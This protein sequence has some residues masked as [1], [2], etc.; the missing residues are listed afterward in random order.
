MA[1]KRLNLLLLLL[2]LLQGILCVR[3]QGHQGLYPSAGNRKV[4]P[5]KIS[6]FIDPE[7]GNDK[8]PGT[9]AG[10]A[11][12]TFSKLNQMILSPGDK[13][14]IKPGRFHQSLVLI[15]R[16]SAKAPVLI[17][18]AHGRFDVFPDS[19]YREP[20]HISNTND[21]PYEPKAI[22]L[23]IR[24]SH[25]VQVT[26]RGARLIMRG[27]IIETFINQ[28]E[29]VHV[30]GLSYD[31]HRPTVSELKATTVTALYA[32]LEIHPQSAYSIKDSLLT[33]EGEGWRYQPG[34]YWQVFEPA[35][36]Y[37]YR[38]GI[39]FSTLKIAGTG[40][41]RI[42]A[43][44]SKNPGFTA[45]SIYQNRDVTRDCAGIVLMRS[46]NISLK[47]L[48]IYFMH[49]MGVVSQFCRNIAIDDLT[50][51]PEEHS[52]KTCAAWADILHFSGCSGK[53]MVANSYLSAAN[54]DAIN[55]HGTH[56]RITEKLTDNKL[57]V[58]FMHGQTYGFDPFVPGDTADFIRAESLRSFGTNVVSGVEQ[59]NDKEF[60]LTF[61]NA[62]PYNLK[63]NDV[64]E[65]VTQTPSVW[66]HHTT[67]TLVPT[68]GMLVTTRRKVVIE[69]NHFLRTRYS[70]ILVEDDAE[71]WYESGVVRDV[72]IRKNTFVDCG[73]PV[74]SIHPENHL[75]DGPVHQNIT[76]L[77]NTF[78]L[79]NTKI[80]TA[81]STRNITISQ[82]RIISLLPVTMESLTGFEDCT[83]IEISGNVVK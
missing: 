58:R 75:Y 45:G 69:N 37:V 64:L 71:S 38:Q 4:S 49:G 46:E 8:N 3:A 30:E 41:H 60:I 67:L 65:N 39:Q 22:A 27:K 29:N 19:L 14:S 11:W 80:F 82:N 61:E 26:G 34:D 40:T 55:V 83:D 35:S 23:C 44:F 53:I 13:V 62:V 42:R 52:G 48:R 2:A 15:A 68:R 31:Y 25:H 56:V 33:W 36:G 81:K 54:D 12:R 72:S 24:N 51:K 10:K 59:L 18:F 16:G 1:N 79:K 76:I 47:K 9:S 21:V 6:Y 32:D 63:E 50:V 73:G 5:G 20:L 17:N 43:Y 74:I 77:H 57:K 70:A 78:Q 7:N 66:V 28:S